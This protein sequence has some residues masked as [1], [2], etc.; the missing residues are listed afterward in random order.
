MNAQHEI[1][2]CAVMASEVRGHQTV[3][4]SEL[5]AGIM[6][7]ET[8]VQNRVTSELRTYSDSSYF[9]EVVQLVDCLFYP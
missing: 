5:W 4:R 3:P 6:A 1:V 8:G 7:Q 9:V 2:D